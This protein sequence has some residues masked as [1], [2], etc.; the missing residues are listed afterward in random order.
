MKTAR[1]SL[2]WLLLAGS[3]AS[4]DSLYDAATYRPLATD[5]RAYRKG[6]ILTLLIFESASATTSANSS[7]NRKSKVDVRV[8]NLAS[9]RAGSF[10]SDNQFDGGGTEQRT[11]E[12]LARVSVTVTDVLANGDLYVKG[13][14]NIALNS[15]S[16]R[17]KIEG[18]VRQQDVETDNTVL[19]SRLADAKID[20]K[21]HGLLSSRER[22]G[23]L[24]R[25]F[26]WLF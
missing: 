24:I 20:F 9:A 25:F 2:L 4:A 8:A 3:V 6:D 1:F 18:R 16:Q 11:G 10:N 26:Q 17:I 19:S 15:E 21:G 13:E 14:Q 7:A 22:P 12:V 23:L 5:H